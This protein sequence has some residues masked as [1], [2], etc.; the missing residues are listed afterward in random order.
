MRLFTIGFTKKTAQHFFELLRA[1]NIDLLLDIRL[2]N[3]AQLAG[4][5]KCEDLEYFLK[6]I[7]YCDYSHCAEF[8]P[9][10]DILDHYRDKKIS[11]REYELKY[12]KLI[13]CRNI[14]D[15]ICDGFAERFAAYKNIILLCS[16]PTA[17]KCHRRLAAEA[18]YKAHSNIEITHL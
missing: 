5:T 15:S 14:S 9:T 16:E 17:E 10:K 11:W 2:N 18:I 3:R 7:L 8:A 12:N 13:E 6:E 1:N 4:F